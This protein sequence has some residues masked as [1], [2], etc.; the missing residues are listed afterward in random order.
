MD[1]RR[2]FFGERVLADLFVQVGVEIFFGGDI[3]PRVFRIVAAYLAAARQGG[4]NFAVEIRVGEFFG[5]V[6][7]EQGIVLS[8]PLR[9]RFLGRTFAVCAKTV[10]GAG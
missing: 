8:L 3:E 4:R 7:F 10:A 9:A 5:F 2:F 6:A 1:V